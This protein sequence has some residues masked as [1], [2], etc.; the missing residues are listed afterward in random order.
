MP[1]ISEG[2]AGAANTFSN[3]QANSDPSDQI[4]FKVTTADLFATPQ[5]DAKLMRAS[6]RGSGVITPATITD[7]DSAFR[8]MWNVLAVQGYRTGS[9]SIGQV[10]STSTTTLTLKNKADIV[11]FQVGMT[12]D[13]DDVDGGGTVDGDPTEDHGD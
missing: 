1:V 7:F 12:I 13:S 3:A 6:K 4:A 10:G 5:I 9:G 2:H 8:E 11:N